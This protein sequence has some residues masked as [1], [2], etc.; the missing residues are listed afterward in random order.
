MDALECLQFEHGAAQVLIANKTVIVTVEHTE[1]DVVASLIV[2]RTKLVHVAVVHSEVYFSLVLVKYLVGKDR[3][4]ERSQCSEAQFSFS[5]EL[6]LRK[7]ES[8]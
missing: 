4:Q 3:Q 5:F 2:D 6:L 1:K 8:A 7:L